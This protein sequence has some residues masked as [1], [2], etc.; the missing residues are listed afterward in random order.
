MIPVITIVGQPNV[1]KSTLFNRL[2]RS[3]DALVADQ[4]GVTRDRQYGHIHYK[5]QRAILVD[6]GGISGDKEGVEA[7][8]MS[9]VQSAIEEANHLLFV[10]DARLSLT[11]ADE[12]IAR[13]LRRH[14][15]PVTLV[16]NKSDGLDERTVE[17]EFH[18]LGMTDMAC[19][20][21]AH[22]RG[23]LTLLDDTM[24]HFPEQDLELDEELYPGTRV[25][26]IGRPNVGKSTLVN[27]LLGEERVIAY[28]Q[29]GTTRD[30]V[31]I[32]MEREGKPYTLIDTAGIRRRGKVHD[33]VEKFSVIK[34]LQAIEACHVCLLLVDA[35]EGLVEQDLS[36]LGH[37]LEAGRS[38]VIAVNKW[39]GLEDDVKRRLK[40]EL[41]RR[42]SFI[43]Y[44]KLHKISAKYGTGVGLLID[45]VDA[46]FDSA[47]CKPSTNKLSQI[48]E[49]ACTKHPPPLV[50]GRRIKLRYA[51]LGG[52]NPP[53]VVIHGNQTKDVP[54]SYTRYLE[55]CYRKA[56][57]LVGTPVHIE[58]KTGENPYAGRR[59]TLTPRQ[60]RKKRRMMRHYK[61]Q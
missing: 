32:S 10:V 30:S 26:V 13:E 43:N 38:L 34:S 61:K 15:K 16:V 57:K 1:G 50:K 28:D 60:I 46:A 4:P 56:L 18:Q 3:R 59:N 54:Q 20:A 5:G 47:M 21:A 27:R 49:T 11:P 33:A 45:S 14:D 41:D 37:I 25:A 22:N 19:I 6:T 39:D 2:T 40:D 24:A 42:L 23:V 35:R 17:A 55:N 8:M 31:F 12:I 36:L 44:A 52:S 48:L 29:P 53:L 9:Q 58:Y 7:L 51:H